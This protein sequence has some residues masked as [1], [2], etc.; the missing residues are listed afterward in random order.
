MCSRSQEVCALVVVFRCNNIHVSKLKYWQVRGTISL[1]NYKLWGN[2]ML[3]EKQGHVASDEIRLMDR[4]FLKMLLID[5]TTK[6]NILWAS[7]DYSALGDDYA[8]EREITPEL[9][10]YTEKDLVKP[11]VLKTVENQGSRTRDMA[12][13]FTPSWVCNCQNNLVDNQ[14]F[15]RENVFNTEI[16]Q[17]WEANTDKIAFP[18]TKDRSWKAYVDCRRLEMTCGEAPYLVSRY[19]TASGANIPLQQ[20]IG[21]LDRKLRVVGENTQSEE[22]WIKWAVRAVQ[23]VY[24]YEFQGDSLFLARQNVFLTF[25]DYYEDRFGQVPDRKLLKK[26]ANIISW[27][28]WQM[29]G[30]KYVVPYSCKPII[31]DQGSLFGDGPEIFPCPGC[32]TG[33][34]MKHTGIYCRIYDWR[35]T[36]SYAYKDIVKGEKR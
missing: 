1:T 5:K 36:R 6:Q 35:R 25:V 24:G 2:S 21:L 18:E 17:G 9:L 30:T 32:D 19:D 3:P 29:D 26:I 8:P 22:D 12:E 7:D 10:S 20:R 4:T 28:L 27:N 11:R 23:S 16:V 14:W 31:H 33:D 34:P 13:V 15:G